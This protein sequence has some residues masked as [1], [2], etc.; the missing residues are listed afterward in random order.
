MTTMPGS[1]QHRHGT[2]LRAATITWL[3]LISAA[4]V[5]DHVALS[6]LSAQ[7]ETNAPG[8][9]VAVLEKR[10][11]ELVQQVEQAQQQP[12][13][14]PQARYEVEHQALEQRLNAIEQALGSRP[15]A[16][17]LLPLQAR[18]EQ[19]E[20]RLSTP[21]PVPPAQ[22]RPLAAPSKPKV[23]ET[24]FR[25]IAAELRAGERF[26][27]ILPAASS[28]LSQVRLLRPGEAEA[29]WHLETIEGNTAVFRHGDDI[30]RLPVPA[31]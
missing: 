30:R 1:G 15:T 13:A 17:Y 18:I 29:G 20:M 7:V 14:L 5:I 6:G 22:P 23:V 8:L 10:L 9:K 21:R 3:L 28:A 11:A 2:L 27:S 26:L 25:V 16:D 24:Q 31:Q 12:D 4:V 19:L